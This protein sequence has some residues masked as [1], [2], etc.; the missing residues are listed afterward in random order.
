MINIFHLCRDEVSFGFENSDWGSSGVATTTKFK[1]D[2]T[3]AR[4]K[5]GMPAF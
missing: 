5:P 1:S 3:V 4:N 2:V